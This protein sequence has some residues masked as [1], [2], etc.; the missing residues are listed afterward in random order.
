VNK[1]RLCHKEDISFAAQSSGFLVLDK[2]ADGIINNGSEMFGPSTG[3][4]FIDLSI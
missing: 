3:S 1:E 2:N 4:G